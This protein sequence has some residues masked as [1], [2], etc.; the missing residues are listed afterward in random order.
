VPGHH[1]LVGQ[2]P[3]DLL[4]SVGFAVVDLD[5][6]PELRQT[7]DDTGHPVPERGVEHEGLGIGVVEQVSEILVEVPVVHVD[8]DTP[9]LERC[10]LG[11]EVLVAVVEVQPDLGIGRQS[12]RR[13]RGRNP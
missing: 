5:E 12:G 13:V 9:H 1:L 8:G 2:S 4:R 11:F 7:V 10:V 6:Q 3:G